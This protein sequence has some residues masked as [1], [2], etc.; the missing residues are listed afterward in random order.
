M[1][2]EKD[3]DKLIATLTLQLQE[4]D[5]AIENWKTMYESVMQTCNNDAKEIDRLREQIAE[6]DAEIEYIKATTVLIELC[7]DAVNQTAIAEL[8]KVIEFAKTQDEFGFR[9]SGMEIFM[10]VDQQIRVLKGD[11]NE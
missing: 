10:F 6:K 3:K 9:K 7:D 2:M 4:K 8:E 1:I 11:L 5:Q